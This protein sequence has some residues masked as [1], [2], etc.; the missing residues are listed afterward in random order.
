MPQPTVEE[1]DQRPVQDTDADPSVGVVVDSTGADVVTVA[2]DEQTTISEA[3]KAGRMLSQTNASAI[4]DAVRQLLVVLERAG[5]SMAADEEPMTEE[6]LKAML[7]SPDRPVA[8]GS[9]I[10]ALGNGRFGGYGVVYGSDQQ[11]DT[12]GE[13][14]TKDTNYALDWFDKRPL[15][16]AHGL[17]QSVK[18]MPFG[19]VDT[20]KQDDVGLYAEG[21]FIDPD[22]VKEWGQEQRKIH[23]WYMGEIKRMMNEGILYYSSGSVKHLVTAVNGR[24]DDWPII[25][26]SMTPA[27]AFPP[28]Y[29]KT[30]T[31]QAFKSLPVSFDAADAETDAL[32]EEPSAKEASAE[33]DAPVVESDAPDAI[34]NEPKLETE[35]PDTGETKAMDVNAVLNAVETALG[36]TLTEEQRAQVMQALEADAPTEEA[37]ATMTEAQTKA[38]V[39]AFAQKAIAAVGRAVNGQK[40]T[41][42][43]VDAIKNLAQAAQPQ[44]QVTGNG[45]T[46]AA[47]V[48]MTDRRYDHLSAKDMVFGA[49]VI[50]DASVKGIVAPPNE[51]FLRVTAEKL[52]RAMEKGEHEGSYEAG[53]IKDYVHD[54][55]RGAA[56][57]SD[58]ILATNLA[59][60]GTNWVGVAY[61]NQLWE[62]ARNRVVY[63]QL[64]AKGMMQ[65]EVSQGQNSIYI[66]AEGSDPTWYTMV[67]LN[68]ETSDERA[69][70]VVKGST[71]TLNRRQLTPAGLGAR[72]RWTDFMDEDSLVSLLPHY[73]SR[74]EITAA[75]TLENVILNGDTD[76]SSSTN[77]N[78]I[79]GTPSTDAKGRGA[80]YLAF[81]GLL[82]LALV[83]TTTLSRS[84]GGAISD[85]D[86]VQTLALLPS[87]EQEENDSLLFVVDPATYLA[88]LRL[89]QVKTQSELGSA[90]TILSGVLRQMYGIDLARSGQMAKANS[91][92][93]IP[94]AGGTLGRIAL[95]R[96]DQ[97]AIGFKRQVT[98]EVARDIEGG[99]TVIVSTMRVAVQSRTT[100][101]GV[102]VTYNV[103]VA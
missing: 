64:I 97:W 36:I 43:V 98:T 102:A 60:N 92:G 78:L 26:L 56:I 83:T 20:L 77:I 16:Y 95:V 27:P 86:Y 41:N 22:T 13:Y 12:D 46:G 7:V 45:H 80:A 37:M 99:A 63:Q 19:V 42:G 32:P 51:H 85:E 100:T 89:A 90:A 71:P 35:Q 31:I 75:E 5:V 38:A 82:K 74:M 23:R 59:N 52:D 61:S 3:T 18:T 25:E 1:H 44:S 66:P 101:G 24:I 48:E 93:K 72:V 10:K 29:S 9:A 34:D 8:Y 55:A 79:D 65:L 49:R 14:F 40:A 87:N 6:T 4:M 84:A 94:A 76:T 28:I 30:T 69:P 62:A 21:A 57:K 91:A 17:D 47:R 33:A 2:E 58:E 50:A 67:E 73:R 54:L 81:N 15:I 88:S 39:D 96:P 103:G 70:V 11:R 68:D 53:S